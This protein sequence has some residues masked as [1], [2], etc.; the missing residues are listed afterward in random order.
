MAPKK[1][2]DYPRV[3]RIKDEDIRETIRL[4]WN[5]AFDHGDIIDAQNAAI[6]AANA[7]IDS[8]NTLLTKVSQQVVRLSPAAGTDT[9]NPAIPQPGGG[10]GGTPTPPSGGDGGEGNLG[11][12]E[13]G[14]NGHL[15]PGYSMSIE[16]VGKIICGTG[17]EFPTLL[18]IAVDQPTRD[19]NM[20]ELL[21]RMIWHINLAGFTAARYGTTDGRPWLLLFNVGSTQY[22]YRVIEYTASD[23]TIPYT[24]VMVY[25]GQTDNSTTPPDGGTPD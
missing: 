5:K 2:R 10:G 18:A 17:N 24:T 19:A 16:S 6:A 12:S 13:A 9:P 14:T 4:L 7:T 25:G 21:N 8:Q 20:D 1:Q 3:N 22:A 11:C 23:Y 15:D